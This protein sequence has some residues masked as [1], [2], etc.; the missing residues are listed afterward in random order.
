MG[1]SVASDKLSCLFYH[2]VLEGDPLPAKDPRT[3][4]SDQAGVIPSFTSQA[5][6]TEALKDLKEF[7][8]GYTYKVS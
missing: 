1:S 8:V 7:M 4:C 6:A 3:Y 5:A 2:P